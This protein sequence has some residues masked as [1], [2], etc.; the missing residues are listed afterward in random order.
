MVCVLAQGRSLRL[1]HPANAT[2]DPTVAL[3]M[4]WFICLLN[5]WIFDLSFGGLCRPGHTSCLQSIIQHSLHVVV[6][7]VC[8]GKNLSVQTLGFQLKSNYIL[9]IHI[10]EMTGSLYS[11]PT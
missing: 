5:M 4:F 9:S 2:L 8:S 10:P 3:S 11:F 7:L 6:T 1:L